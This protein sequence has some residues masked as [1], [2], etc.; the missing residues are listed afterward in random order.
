MIR[1]RLLVGDCVEVM[2]DWPDGVVDLTVTSPPYDDMR[3]YEGYRFRFAEIAAALLRVT[4]PGGVCVWV[5]GDRIRQG[6]R[7]LTSFKQAIHFQEIGWRVHDVMTWVK[8]STPFMRSNAYRPAAELMLV[9]SKGAPATV[10]LLT[11]P[12]KQQGWKPYAQ[13]NKQADGVNKYRTVKLGEETPRTNVWTYGTGWM[14]NTPD[15]VAYGHPAIFPDKL[16]ADHILS[17][18][19]PG[20]LVLDPMMGSGTTPKMAAM[21]GRDFVGIDIAAEYVAIAEERMSLVTKP[22]PLGDTRPHHQIRI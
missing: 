9:L 17:W 18:S 19:N 22:L 16:A 13:H 8:T 4:K 3:D 14:V 11:Q 5:V 1:N 10:N 12:T 6:N 7:T 15:K 21:L 20:D 2:A